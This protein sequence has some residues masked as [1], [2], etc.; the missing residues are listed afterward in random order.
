MA[1]YLTIK[2][3]LLSCCHWKSGLAYPR[4]SWN[5]RKKVMKLLKWYYEY[6][7]VLE[8]LLYPVCFFFVR[9]IFLPWQFWQKRN[10]TRQR[11]RFSLSFAILI[12]H[13]PRNFEFTGFPPRKNCRDDLLWLLHHIGHPPFFVI[14][15]PYTETI[16]CPQFKDEGMGQ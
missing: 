12:F 1:W 7:N 2:S 4:G 13:V 11:S 10:K 3:P 8:H 16:W 6:H 15:C 9:P 14:R 5:T